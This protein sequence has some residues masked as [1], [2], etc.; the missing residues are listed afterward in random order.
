MNS[1]KN[2]PKDPPVINIDTNNFVRICK[3]GH[4]VTKTNALI[5]KQ[6]LYKCRLCINLCH[7]RTDV[8]KRQNP[9][10]RANIYKLHKEYRERNPFK[11]RARTKLQRA[12]FNG[13]IIKPDFCDRCQR[14]LP[15]EGHH[16]DYSRAFDVLWLCKM[17]HEWLHH[18]KVEV[19]V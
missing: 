18:T 7:R 11:M 6:G 15:V 3:R 8:K 5:T 14:Y 4:I 9:K 19:L 13:Y 10:Y 17:C 12:V 16:Y 2:P 1:S